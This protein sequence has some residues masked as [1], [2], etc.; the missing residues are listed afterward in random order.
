MTLEFQLQCSSDGRAKVFDAY[1]YPASLIDS[2][3]ID[4]GFELESGFRE[5]VKWCYHFSPYRICSSKLKW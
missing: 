5:D 1:F 4:R 2:E 3:K